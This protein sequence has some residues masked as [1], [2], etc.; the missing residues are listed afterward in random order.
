MGSNVVIR[1]AIPDDI[2]QITAL[3]TDVVNEIYGHLFKGSPH[4]SPDFEFWL[5]SW[6][7]TRDSTVVGVGLAEGDYVED[8]WVDAQFRS[9]RI[10][11]ALLS[12]L[13]GQIAS[14][15]HRYGR[16]RVVAENHGAKKFYAKQGWRKTKTYPHERE[17]FLMVDFQKKLGDDE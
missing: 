14:K 2:S 12:K 4:V 10:G 16:L 11:S 5:Q 3:V 6:V 8:L 15:G 17:G 9:K 1:K 13:E 7:A